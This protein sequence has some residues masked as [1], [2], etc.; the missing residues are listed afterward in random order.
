[1]RHLPHRWALAVATALAMSTVT[2]GP[3]RADIAGDFNISVSDGATTINSWIPSTCPAALTIPASLG[4]APVTKIEFRAFLNHACLQTD[5]GTTSVTIPAGV[6][7]VAGEAFKGASGLQRI[8]FTGALNSLPS[9]VF[10]GNT[11]LKQ[12]IFQGNG[13]TAAGDTF[14][15]VTDALV[16]YRSGTQ[17]RTGP[18]TLTA[19]PATYATFTTYVL[20]EVGVAGLL[21]GV[22][23]KRVYF[24]PTIAATSPGTAYVRVFAKVRKNGKYRSVL[25]CR[26]QG[27]IPVASTPVTL[28][29]ASRAAR[30][31]VRKRATTFTAR[32]YL[33]QV[34]SNF[35]SA[36]ATDTVRVK[37]RR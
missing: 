37:R 6:S 16:F 24:F 2:S 1:M 36:E 10:S 35:T 13:P 33:T 14:A 17:L 21:A 30:T 19:W 23:R 3:A 34:G 28:E 20:P 11:S 12:I 15:G 26:V 4:G 31:L 18:S 22:S 7:T 9:Q 27:T 8:T 32:A 29:C 5:G 25:I